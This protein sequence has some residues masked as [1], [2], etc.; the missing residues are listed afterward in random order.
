MTRLNLYG[1]KDGSFPFKINE[2][3]T[4]LM[5]RDIFYNET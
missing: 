1:N 4:T 3:F 5:L 2:Y